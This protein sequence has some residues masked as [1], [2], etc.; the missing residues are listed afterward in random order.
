MSTIGGAVE[1]KLDEATVESL[2]KSVTAVKRDI[3]KETAAALV[4]FEILKAASQVVSGEKQI[5]LLSSQGKQYRVEILVV[6]WEGP[7]FKLLSAKES[8]SL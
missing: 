3:T 7:S 5:I 6:P 4:D 2:R 1:K 8:D